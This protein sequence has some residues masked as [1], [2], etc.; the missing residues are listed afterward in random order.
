MYYEYYK[1]IKSIKGVVNKNVDTCYIQAL[2][3]TWNE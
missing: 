1:L 3:C 2:K